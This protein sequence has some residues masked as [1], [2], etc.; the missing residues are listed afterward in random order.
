MKAFVKPFVNWLSLRVICK[1]DQ[2][3]R[4]EVL[5]KNILAAFQLVPNVILDGVV[6]S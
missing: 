2:K 1:V 3:T 5:H 6:V 4:V